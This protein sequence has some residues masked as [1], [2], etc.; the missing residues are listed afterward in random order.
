MKNIKSMTVR[1]DL[2]A[3]RD[4]KV[5]HYIHT[6]AKEIHKNCKNAVIEEIDE[7]IRMKVQLKNLNDL[8][9][10]TVKTAIR[11]EFSRMIRPVQNTEIIEETDNSESGDLI[12]NIDM[13]FMF[14]DNM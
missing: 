5:W 10:D 6:S 7:N 13:K 14:G 8:L 11:D 3:E 9:S 2:D 4:S 1:F 12:E